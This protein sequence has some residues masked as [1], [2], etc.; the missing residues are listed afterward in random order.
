MTQ[1]D[2]IGGDIFL[3]FQLALL[4][5]QAIKRYFADFDE[6]F[7]VRNFFLDVDRRVAACCGVGCISCF[8]RNRAPLDVYVAITDARYI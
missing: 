8:K 1:L 7:T 5:A 6:R 3:F 4:N 2:N